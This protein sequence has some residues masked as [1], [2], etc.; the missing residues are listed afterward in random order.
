MQA[1]TACYQYIYSYYL[2]LDVAGSSSVRVSLKDFWLS[3]IGTCASVVFFRASFDPFS[4]L[5]GLTNFFSISSNLAVANG[6]VP[7]VLPE[8]GPSMVNDAASSLE[9]YQLLPQ[10]THSSWECNKKLK[11]IIADQILETVKV[12]MLLPKSDQWWIRNNLRNQLA[13]V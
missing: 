6:A 11:M 2:A 10:A 3:N 9:A 12:I 1:T 8:F 4:A 13:I 7:T 5:R